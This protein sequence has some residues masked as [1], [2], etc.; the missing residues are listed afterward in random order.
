MNYLELCQRVRQ[1][2]GVSG[3]GPAAINGQSGILARIVVW[4]KNAHN[5]IQL[6]N[7]DWRFLWAFGEGRTIVGH[8]EYR[9][10]DFGVAQF[11]T[12]K[13]F[14]CDKDELIQRDWDWYLREVKAKGDTDDTGVPQYFIVKPDEKILL[15]PTPT[16]EHTVNVD[17]YKR[18]VQLV[19]GTD[20]PVIPEEF[21]EAIVC[22][23]LMYYAHHEEDTYLFQTKLVEYNEW[24]NLLS[25]SQQPQITF[26]QKPQI[27]FK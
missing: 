19:N 11:R 8:R 25:Q 26:E 16:A 23:A 24:V 21:H 12:I 10:A 1:D 22:R 7:T 14:F 3:E 5:Q 9:P 6:K 27:R 2:S 4:V 13:S 17:Y 20:N 18:P 15:Y